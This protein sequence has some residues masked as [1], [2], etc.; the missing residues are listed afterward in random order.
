MITSQDSMLQAS[1]LSMYTPFKLNAEMETISEDESIQ[2]L[3]QAT[4]A[5]LQLI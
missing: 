4:E 3:Q 1:K 2:M 5:A